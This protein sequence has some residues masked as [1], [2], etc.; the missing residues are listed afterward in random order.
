MNV[1]V[2][3]GRRCFDLDGVRES[4]DDGTHE[5]AVSLDAHMEALHAAVQ[6]TR[7]C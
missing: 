3:A 5:R 2:F 1:F 6:I 7:G 4:R